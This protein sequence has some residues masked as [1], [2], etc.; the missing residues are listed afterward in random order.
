MNNYIIY[1]KNN[2]YVNFV[3]SCKKIVILIFKIF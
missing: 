1:N 2:E 3:F